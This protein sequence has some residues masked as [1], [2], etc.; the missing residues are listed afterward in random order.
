MKT[1]LQPDCLIIKTLEK[2]LQGLGSYKNV[3][4]IQEKTAPSAPPLNLA[5]LL[6]EHIFVLS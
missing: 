3:L 2:R 4:K 5:T 6:N 1:S